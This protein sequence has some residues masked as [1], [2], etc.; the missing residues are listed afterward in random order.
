[1]EL[2][3]LKLYDEISQTIYISDMETYD[4]VFLNRCGRQRL[5][6]QQEQEVYGKCYQ[7]LQGLDNPCSFCNNKDLPLLF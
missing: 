3:D 4:L 7:V 2:K 6:I 5:G 1:M